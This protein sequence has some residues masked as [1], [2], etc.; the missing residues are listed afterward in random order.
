VNVEKTGKT[1]ISKDY[2]IA[3]EY[4]TRGSGEHME[5]EEEVSETERRWYVK[6]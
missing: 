3:A 2:I 5:C 4:E 1:E 6:S